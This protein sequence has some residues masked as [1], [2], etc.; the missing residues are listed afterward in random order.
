MKFTKSPSWL[1]ELFDALQPE[2]GGDRRQMFG[3]PV[4]F[5]NGQ[6]FCGLFADGMFV[7]LG[8]NDRAELLARPG[9]TA[10]SPMQGRPM[11][12]Y[13]VLPPA[14]LEDEEAVI[15]WLRRG[16]AFARSLPPKGKKARPAKSARRR[17]P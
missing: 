13:V 17:Q 7:R 1:V 6:L 4:A 2:V 10:F 11:R 14:M 9:A 15:G 16:L 12:E 8:E 5:A 3:Y